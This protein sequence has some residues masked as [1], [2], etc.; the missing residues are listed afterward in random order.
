MRF[1]EL[2]HTADV[3]IRAYGATLEEL[4]ENAAAGMSSLIVDLESV[5]PRGEVEVRVKADDLEGLLV[6]WLQELLFLH[7]TQHLVFC[8]FDVAIGGLDLTG[9]A[10]GEAIDKRRHELKLAVKAVTYHR[11]KVDPEKGVAEV[12]FDI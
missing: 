9:R 5:K 7:E 6:N 8:E 3:G 1:E 12:I 10:R 4:F 11:L 2:D